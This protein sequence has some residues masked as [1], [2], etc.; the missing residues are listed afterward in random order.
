MKPA[1]I[2]PNKH[3]Q[4]NFSRPPEAR[5]RRVHSCEFPI[6]S[7]KRGFPRQ[8]RGSALIALVATIVVFSVLAVAIVPMISSSSRQATVVN[9]AA[10]SYLLAESGYR[11]AASRFLNAGA[12]ERDQNDT[13]EQLDNGVFTLSDGDSRFELQVHSFFYEMT[14]NVTTGPTS[15]TAR[16]PG[17]FPDDEV[18]L[19]QA[20]GRRVRIGGQTY[21]L[22]SAQLSAGTDD[23]VIFNSTIPLSSY[24]S[25]TMVFPVALADNAQTLDDHDNL[26][27]ETD[28]GLMFPLRNGQIQVN[29]RTLAYR[30]NDR[31]NNRFR[32][33]F[34]P[35]G[36]GMTGFQV[37]HQTPII[38]N[39][40]ARLRSAG[41]YGSGAMQTRREV[42][43][44]A[45][46]PIS[47]AATQ[48]KEFTDRFDSATAD[49]WQELSPGSHTVGEVDANNA[50]QVETTVT[51]NTEQGSLIQFNPTSAE[52]EEIDFNAS[53][54]GSKGYLSYDAQIKV[55]YETTPAP[56]N[57]AA[58][59]SFRLSNT[60]P[61]D[62][63]VNDV[64]HSNNFG[65]SFLRANGSAGSGIDDDIIPVRGQ[66]A[67]VL[68]EQTGNGAQ[69]T[70]L[71]YKQ[72][73]DIYFWEDFE[74]PVTDQFSHNVLAWWDPD[75]Q[76]QRTGSSRNWY[77]GHD[78]QRNY[79]FA[80]TLGVIESVP[81]DIPTSASQVTLSFWSWHETEPLRP[82]DSGGFD[83]KQVFI[84]VDGSDV[85]QL[86]HTIDRGPAPGNW[87]LEEV[88][89]DAYIGQ[90]I[91][92]QFSFDSVDN[93]NNAYEGWYVDDVRVFS[94]DEWPDQNATLGVR[95]QEALVV[96]FYG[97]TSEIR[98][99]DR[100]FG[101][102]HGTSGRVMDQPIINNDGE[103]TPLQSSSGTILL[104][105]TSVN[106][107]VVFAVG[108]ELLVMGGSG[109]ASVQSYTEATDRKAN[110]IKVYYASENGHG[111]GNGN[112]DPFD[113]TTKA[114]PRLAS[115]TD[116]LDW[117]PEL[118]PDGHWTA[119]EDFFRFIR[120]DK[121]NPDIGSGLVELSFMT[122]DHGLVEN[123]ILQR[124]HEDLQTP[125]F[126]GTFDAAE[127][128][129]H[130]F[131]EGSTLVYFDDFG[132]QIDVAIDNPLTLPVQQ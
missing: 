52:A 70:W 91:H 39:R 89:L 124:Y 44:Y 73:L 85:A 129:L 62:G 23:H 31:A 30:F 87:Y 47:D 65:L 105:R 1:P 101:A 122:T 110:I 90:T 48:Q 102:I 45:P 8:A 29:G 32:D 46:L 107:S 16:A 11:F 12:Q 93:E 111:N 112:S 20:A 15:F 40:Y 2:R 67:I 22:A 77:Y 72:M 3:G 18:N 80:D 76:R 118:D 63:N 92:I 75:F 5:H 34:D 108:E 88:P 115:D 58:G 114:Y 36:T 6:D 61:G 57:V 7:Q 106:S 14:N 37:P 9:L 81:I 69:R 42:V 26:V 38:L 19:S 71:A 41:I 126:P 123:A 17:T 82:D 50:L 128:G 68:W 121:I 132:M 56:Q 113:N 84:R 79:D 127:I 104:N 13:L 125:D 109:R 83:R 35:Y 59:L 103:W 49:D 53:R 130:T 21:V 117:P 78:I 54:R 131:G 24:S 95:L 4:A 98:K 119:D 100:I 33:V 120:W 43:Y 10:K 74:D 28:D 25:G 51:E 27:Y 55:G 66:R 64:F 94:A 116:T 60:D 99:G 97:G 96:R 86:V